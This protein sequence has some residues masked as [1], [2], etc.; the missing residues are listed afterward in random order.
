MSPITQA[1]KLAM[2]LGTKSVTYVISGQGFDK[3][4]NLTSRCQIKDTRLHL[5]YHITHTTSSFMPKELL[6]NFYGTF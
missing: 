2:T 5:T 6:Q 3:K 1:I 4:A